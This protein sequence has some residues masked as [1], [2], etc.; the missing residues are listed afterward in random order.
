MGRTWLF[1]AIGAGIGIQWQKG[2]DYGGSGEWLMEA[3]ERE[4][5][6]K[7]L[8]RNTQKPWAPYLYPGRSPTGGSDEEA[9]KVF[10]FNALT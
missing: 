7:R 8:G 4:C 9:G 1:P 5:G 10:A 2:K 6:R 3:K